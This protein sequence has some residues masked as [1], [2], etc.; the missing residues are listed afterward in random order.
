MRMS[1]SHMLLLASLSLGITGCVNSSADSDTTYFLS[2]E[3]DSN[4]DEWLNGLPEDRQVDMFFAS[5][6]TRP[7]SRTVD[8]WI[9]EDNPRFIYA[10]RR[11][12]PRRGSQAD[13]DAFFFIIE[14]IQKRSGLSSEELS[15][16][17]LR[18]LCLELETKVEGC[19]LKISQVQKE[20]QG[21]S[22]GDW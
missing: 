10:L 6:K 7:M 2:M 17:R 22:E 9:I 8:Y 11:S 19:E 1:I 12:L 4:S 20:P 21:S 3:A 16:L 18:E 13:L 14:A 15:S 5:H